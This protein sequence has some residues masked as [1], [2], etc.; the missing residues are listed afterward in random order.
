MT[1]KE[2]IPPEVPAGS[3]SASLY[4][5]ANGLLKSEGDDLTLIGVVG[6]SYFESPEVETN[7]LAMERLLTNSTVTEALSLIERATRKPA[8]RFD[9]SYERGAELLVPYAPFLL[10]ASRAYT[11]IG[12]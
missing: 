4:M 7:R 1:L 10:M 5:A 12:S 2:I 3:N 11:L 8:C 6:K 9:V